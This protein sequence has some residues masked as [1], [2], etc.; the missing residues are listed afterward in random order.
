MSN[1]EEF[2]DRLPSQKKKKEFLV[3]II[4]CMLLLSIV[5]VY[6][7]IRNY[8]ISSENFPII[9]IATEQDMKTGDYVDGTFELNCP[10]THK[11]VEPIDFKIK[12]RGRFNKYNDVIPKK[13]YRFELSEPTSLLG[14]REDDDWMLFAMYSDLPRMQIKLAMELYQL[15]LTS[16][17][18]AILPDSEYVIVYINRELQGLYLLVEK[19]DR[20]LFALDD[21]INDISSS[22][23]F[24]SA[25]PHKNFYFYEYD[26]WE[27]D[28]PN[29][30]EGI[31]I[32][33]SIMY[34]LIDYIQYTPD[35]E[36]F[37][38]ENGIYTKF[39][40]QN[41]IDFYV[42]N[43]FILHDDFWEHNFFIVRNSF[44]GKAFLVPWD[45]DR[46]FGQ[47]LRRTSDPDKNDESFAREHNLLFDRLLKSAEFKN[48]CKTRWFNLRD[49]IWTENAIIDLLSELYDEIKDVL[50]IDTDLWYHYL[51]KE[52]WKE[53][54]DKSIDHVFDWIPERLEFC[55]TY[56]SEF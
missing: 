52:N 56:F 37:S 28:W 18:T 16:N 14:M 31:Y 34:E 27:Q 13:G 51:W 36:F 38:P 21:A 9:N 50:D 17:P 40:R 29:E 45:F 7:Y 35:E 46:C 42:F 33:D 12:I 44:P 15:L 49:T 1:Q 23:I 22:F 3:I 47:W 53:E 4:V 41:L 11:N 48:E 2:I 20:R 30:Y 55:D 25:E 43:F 19:N 54:I 32:M 5:F 26:K 10:D 6:T 39:D 24:Q 8:P